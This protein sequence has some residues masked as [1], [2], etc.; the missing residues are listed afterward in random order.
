MAS[1]LRYSPQALADLDKVWDD[2]WKV[3]KDYDTADK[4]ADELAYELSKKKKAPKTGIPLYYRGLFTGFYSV[5]YKAYK[6]FYRIK[7][8]YIEVAR[9]LPAKSD[10]IVLLFDNDE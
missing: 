5:N 4:Y 1:K 8:N 3:S 2:V 6:A 10:Y 9:I 7:E